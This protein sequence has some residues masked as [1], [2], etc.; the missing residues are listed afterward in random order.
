VVKC[1]E[2]E[3]HNSIK[4]AI[5]VTSLPPISPTEPKPNCNRGLHL[6]SG[7]VL[8]FAISLSLLDM[9]YLFN[10]YLICIDNRIPSFTINGFHSKILRPDIWCLPRKIWNHLFIISQI[11]GFSRIVCVNLTKGITEGIRGFT[12]AESSY[13]SAR[14][15]VTETPTLFRDYLFT[16]TLM[17][18]FHAFY[19]SPLASL[20]PP[21]LLRIYVARSQN[22]NSYCSAEI[23]CCSLPSSIL[24]AHFTG[25]F[26]EHLKKIRYKVQFLFLCSCLQTVV[27]NSIRRNAM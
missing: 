20:Y 16:K 19:C 3:G 4:Y 27:C 15:K 9:Q 24:S 22:C 13:L 21:A 1:Q 26:D 14:Y 7:G 8:L 12:R 2:C 25:T 5:A 17:F 11:S 18:L 10:I 6:L 23:P